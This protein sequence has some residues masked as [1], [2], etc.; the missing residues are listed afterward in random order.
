MHCL[1][2]FISNNIFLLKHF[3]ISG[4]L[5]CNT[6][7]RD[8][9]LFYFIETNIVQSNSRI[10]IY[11]RIYYISGIYNNNNKSWK[12][13]EDIWW[14][15]RNYVSIHGRFIV[16]CHNFLPISECWVSRALMFLIFEWSISFVY[17]I[18]SINTKYL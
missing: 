13:W 6:S 16:G 5:L 10:E 12:L 1:M 11:I 9:P 14:N 18:L 17:F 8:R 7:F 4:L 2:P 15:G 3:W